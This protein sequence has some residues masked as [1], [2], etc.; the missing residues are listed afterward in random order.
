MLGCGSGGLWTSAGLSSLAQDDG[1]SRPG[2]LLESAAS[3]ELEEGSVGVLKGSGLS[4]GLRSAWARAGFRESR[5]AGG[6]RIWVH[7]ASERMG[8]SG[9]SGRQG[10]S[11]SVKLVQT[12]PLIFYLF[13]NVFLIGCRSQA[14]W[15]VKIELLFIPYWGDL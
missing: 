10:R 2:R 9:S 1:V 12:Q 6:A 7:L 4:L 14:L 13:K 15:R 5:W 8:L 11:N 3:D